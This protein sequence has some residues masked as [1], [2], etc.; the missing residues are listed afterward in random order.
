M[1]NLNRKASNFLFLTFLF[2]VLSVLSFGQ[3]MKG[4]VGICN[5]QSFR[6]LPIAYYTP[7]TRLA[8]GGLF[9]FMFCLNKD[10]T[11]SRRSNF[12]QYITFTIN[13]QFI[14]ENSWQIYSKLEKYAFSGELDYTRFPELFFGIGNNTKSEDHE[15]YSFDKF[16]LSSNNLQNLGEKKFLGLQYN[17][18]YLYNL[19][20][21]EAK[22]MRFDHIPGT[23]GFFIHGFGPIFQIDKRD[24]LLNTHKGM[25]LE[26]SYNFFSK[27][28]GSQF[29][30]HNFILDAR[31]FFP[32]KKFTLALNFYANTNFGELPYRAMPAIGGGRFLRGYYSGRYR[33]NN[34]LILQTEF[35]G[36]LFWRFG[37]AVFTGLGRVAHTLDEFGMDGWKYNMGGGI[38]FKI[39][40]KENVNVRLDYG[41]TGESH[42]IYILFAE[43][44]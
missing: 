24:N 7:E 41:Y 14:L 22:M 4:Q 38:R 34:M 18:Q 37:F 11:I 35:R 10:D 2:L 19:Q 16:K 36:D 31:K 5:K 42:G 21:K 1:P 29:S 17:L 27:N 26:L 8:F 6:V 43:A 23:D 15:Y 3:E 28:L 40:R 30:Y 20:T 33:D 39:N 32:I 44:F 13:K 9:Y 25:Y 12:Q